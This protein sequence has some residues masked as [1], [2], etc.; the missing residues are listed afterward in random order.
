MAPEYA[1]DG[2]FSIKSNVF[3]FGV[4]VLEIVTGMKNR[5]FRVLYHGLNLL[6]HVRFFYIIISF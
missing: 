6:G 4:M 3:S 5:E 1:V 2:D